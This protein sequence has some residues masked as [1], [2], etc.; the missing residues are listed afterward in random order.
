MY[1]EFQSIHYDNDLHADNK[2]RKNHEIDDLYFRVLCREN[3][4]TIS[5]VRVRLDVSREAESPGGHD[6]K[7]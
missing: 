4:L 2:M 3:F 6:A 1:K 7:A 5:L